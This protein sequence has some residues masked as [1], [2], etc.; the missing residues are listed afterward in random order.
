MPRSHD[1][2]HFYKY[3]TANTAEKILESGQFLWSAP[4][5]FND[6]FDHQVT[7]KF[8]FTSAEI[9]DKLCE[10]Q[11]RISF[12]EIEPE[13]VQQKPLGTLSL[14]LRNRELQDKEKDKVLSE[15]RKGADETASLLGDYQENV[16]NLLIEFLSHSRVFCVSETNENVVMWSHYSEQHRGAVIKLNCVDKVDD[17][18]LIARPIKY[19][20]EFPEYISLI[21]WVEEQFGLK[22]IDYEDLAFKLAYIKH[23]DWSYEREWRV[24]IPLMPN[25]P[26]GDGTSLFSKDPSVFG[27]LYLGCRMPQSTQER[28]TTIARRRYPRM[29]IYQAVK[30]KTS[31]ALNL[32]K[33]K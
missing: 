26:V 32:E 30:S 16:N 19:A 31:F 5:L 4:H 25:M 23:R 18:L 14:K 6:P 3:V 1:R 20:I 28:L 11:E 8:P 13:I 2:S 10:V 15:F 12:G 7:Y 22:I 17:N 29:E 9:A 21:D 24:H 33:I 27:A